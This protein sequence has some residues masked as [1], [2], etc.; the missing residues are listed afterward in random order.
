M[1]KFSTGTRI[2]IYPVTGM[3]R[4]CDGH[5]GLF[6]CLVGAGPRIRLKQNFLVNWLSHPESPTYYVG[7]P[8]A[9]DMPVGDMPAIQS[10]SHDDADR[11]VFASKSFRRCDDDDD[12]IDMA[13]I[14]RE[15]CGPV[16]LHTQSYRYPVYT[17]IMLYTT[18]AD[19][20][21]PKIKSKS[22]I[23][24]IIAYADYVQHMCSLLHVGGSILCA[25]GR[26]SNRLPK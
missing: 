12:D 17:S 24:H 7:R 22:K 9:G 5:D 23:I 13:G 10:S 11:W 14:P 6:G 20:G 25:N 21:A 8:G 18:S 16:T 19:R 3:Q 1:A 15:Y 26:L 2:D 4:G